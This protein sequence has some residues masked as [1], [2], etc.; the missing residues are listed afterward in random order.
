[1]AGFDD[2]N[3]F[4]KRMEP[5]RK[6]FGP[7]KAK[8]I[9]IWEDAICY[10][11]DEVIAL[12]K[13]GNAIEFSAFTGEEIDLEAKT[14]EFAEKLAKI[15]RKADAPEKIWLWPEGVLPT[16]T[17]Y[18]D[19]SNHRFNHD[20][21][22][23]PYMYEVLVPEDVTPVG[24]V[25]V[26][27]GGD[28]GNAT[29]KEGYQVAFDLRDMGYQCF[30]LLNRTNHS[31]WTNKEAGVD[32]ARAIRYVRAHAAQ[33]R[34]PENH[35]AFAGFS[36]GGLTGEGCIEWY[37]GEQKVADI[38][39]G[40]QADE[41]DAY[42]G[43]PDAFLCVYGPRFDGGDFD[44]NGVVYPPTFFAVGREDN[45]MKNLHYV[46]PDLL[47]H[48]VELEVHTFAGV[49]HGQA[50][51]KAYDGCVKYPNFELWEVLADAFMKDVYA[52]Q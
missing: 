11:M 6:V 22:F 39:A 2:L 30:V 9:P 25:V 27:A 8:A 28:H 15:H 45:A 34:V 50:G 13:L 10:D 35:V 44:W 32:A 47:A 21:D 49:P 52:K 1:M 4:M 31:P 18:T 36:N 20:P 38:F 37:S 51:V 3:E 7:V 14:A 33:Y 24:A 46:Y 41:L 48:G 43:A 12:G 5:V 16:I 29:L 42:N 40:Y 19:N 26:C 23:V 17:E